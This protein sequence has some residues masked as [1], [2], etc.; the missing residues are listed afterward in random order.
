MT[1]IATGYSCA[2]RRTTLSIFYP[3]LFPPS[4]KLS[5]MR[6]KLMPAEFSR[7]DFKNNIDSF[8]IPLLVPGEQLLFFGPTSTE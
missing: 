1:L 3:I 8:Q 7:W 2:E 5:K 4:V 6:K